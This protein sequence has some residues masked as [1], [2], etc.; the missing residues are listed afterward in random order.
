MIHDDEV[1]V[2]AQPPDS[3][4]HIEANQ[5]DECAVVFVAQAKLDVQVAATDVAREHDE[6]DG[7]VDLTQ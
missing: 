3:G 4:H 1:D 7:D 6:A 5:R 2:H